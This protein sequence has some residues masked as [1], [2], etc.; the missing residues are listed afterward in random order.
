MGENIF[1]VKDLTIQHHGGSFATFWRAVQDIVMPLRSFFRVTHNNFRRFN[2]L[3]EWHSHP[4]FLSEPSSTDHKTMRGMVENP[5]LGAHFTVLMVVKLN[6][7]E[8]LEG[9]VTVYQTGYQEFRGEL[10]QERAES[11]RLG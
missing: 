11:G 9:S 10:I 8:Q 3:G 5:K 7:T 1:R 6:G 4:S 2:Y